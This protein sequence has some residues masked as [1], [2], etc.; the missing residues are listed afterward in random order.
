MEQQLPFIGISNAAF[1]RNFLALMR[2]DARYR[3][4][5][6]HY[7][8]L[9]GNVSYDWDHFVNFES[10]E[11]VWGVGLGYGY[12]TIAGPIKAQVY[13]SSLTNRLGAYLSFG[14]NF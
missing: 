12:N 9:M 13:W 11:S 7:L 8:S 14:Y 10:G 4:G 2:L 6:N 5:K 3:I 1:R